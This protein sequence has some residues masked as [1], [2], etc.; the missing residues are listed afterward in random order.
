MK[1]RKVTVKNFKAINEATVDLTE[2]NVI[3]GA[4][5]SGKSS[6]LQALHWMFQSAIHRKVRPQ[7]TGGET[8]SERDALYMPTREY[9]NA[10]HGPEYG[11][12]VGSPQLEIS[13]EADC[14]GAEALSATMW[15]KSGRNEGIK[16]HL[17]AENKLIQEIR[18]EQ[19]EVTAYIPGLAGISLEE[20]KRPRVIARRLAAAGDANTVLRNVLH[21]MKASDEG[22]D[23]KRLEGFVSRVVGELSI[24]VT[25]DEDKQSRILA[26]F[27]TAEMRAS[28]PKRFKPLELAGIGFLQVIQIFAYLIYFRPVLLLVDEPDSHLHPATQEK[29]VN[30]L[31][32][33]ANE[34]DTQVIVTTHSPSVV[35][36]LP[37]AARVIWMR[38][39]EVQPEGDTSGRQMMGWGLLDKRILLLTEDS[40]THLLRA[41]LAQWPDLDRMVALWPLHGS[42][43]LLDPAGCASLQALLGG[44]MTLVL[45]RDR[46]FMMPV[47]AE[48]FCKDYDAKGVRVWLTKAA[49]VEGYWCDAEILAEHFGICVAD[50][51][52]WLDDAVD[53]G[54]EAGEDEKCRN[55]KREDLRSKPPLKQLKEKGELGA[56]DDDAVIAEYS[57]L[58]PQHLILGK[59]LVSKIRTVA[60]NN[61]NAA[62][63]SFGKSVPAVPG[64]CL[65][66]DLEQLLRELIA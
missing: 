57:G 12:K 46:D 24:N 6:V 56:F 53:A 66:P 55:K 2:F 62:A 7:K 8:L 58:G 9:R 30:V 4:N 11:N 36:A 54:K 64:S 1:L 37:S 34:F 22:N 14:D 51:K 17:P 61:G 43:K 65:A 27:Q 33:A 48:A 16:V 60:Q 42:A 28:D 31:A 35:R 45:H 47:E 50:A 41:I 59:T 10:G 29:L 49:D 38:D 18:S 15:I 3:V 32:E 19:R 39:G 40:K 63:Y 5:G 52:I 26:D 20:E 25:F 13:L 21:L 23:L 44:S